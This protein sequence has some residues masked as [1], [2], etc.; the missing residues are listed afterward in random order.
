MQ[1]HGREIRG[2]EIHHLFALAAEVGEEFGA[3]V[4]QTHEDCESHMTGNG[5][6]RARE[7]NGQTEL[8]E[9]YYGDYAA[10]VK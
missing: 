7:R 9:K 2:E 1:E 3:P 5:E 6:H 4:E 10:Y 8:V